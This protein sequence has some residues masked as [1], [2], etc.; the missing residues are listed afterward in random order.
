MQKLLAVIIT[1]FL[2]TNLFSQRSA[3]SPYR[4][5]FFNSW[6]V[7]YFNN[8]SIVVL[9][10]NP[11]GWSENE[12]LNSLFYKDN[13]SINSLIK[14]SDYCE[15]LNVNTE[16]KYLNKDILLGSENNTE[17]YFYKERGWNHYWFGFRNKNEIQKHHKRI[18]G[19]KYID[20]IGTQTIKSMINKSLIAYREYIKNQPQRIL[21]EQQRLEEKIRKEKELE[22]QRQKSLEE[23]KANSPYR[24]EIRA[25]PIEPN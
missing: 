1:V 19:I 24:Y 6:G 10:S 23:R 2:T 21:E 5:R 4:E 12:A 15:K 25:K 22:L 8:D 7:L 18:L 16:R 17:F 11:E 20:I 3:S 13:L 9:D 14:Y